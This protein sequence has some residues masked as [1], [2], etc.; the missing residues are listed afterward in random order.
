MYRYAI[1]VK[2]TREIGPEDSIMI[3]A[4]ALLAAI[5]SL[6]LAPKPTAFIP[7]D[8]FI[9][10]CQDETML[11]RLDSNATV[12]DASALRRIYILLIA[13]LQLAPFNPQLL[14]QRNSI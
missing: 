9:L 13:Q 12:L 6:E 1:T 3:Q 7:N 14:T 11:D 8:E 10:A 4:K 5:N 2:H